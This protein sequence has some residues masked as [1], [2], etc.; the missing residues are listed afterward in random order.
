MLFHFSMTALHHTPFNP[1]REQ[2]DDKI[3]AYMSPYF[4]QDWHLF[5]PE[6]VTED[7]GF[8]IRAQRSLPD[9][10]VVTTKWVDVTTPH[11]DKLHRQRFWPSRVERLAPAVR[12]R[13]DGWRDPQLEELR[14]EDNPPGSKGPARA[15]ATAEPVPPLA[16]SELA[17]R[18]SALLYARALAS[19]EAA[20][21]W[22][23]SLRSVQVRIVINKYPRFSE[24]AIRAN[25]GKVSYYD[26]AWMKPL[27]VSR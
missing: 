20:K 24:R 22:G 7:S 2:H 9:G 19:A 1:I 26:L 13:L 23:G 17:G 4:Q 15:D 8:L 21:L 12:Q 11:I 14:R 25:R 16:P 18:D 10:A 5:A 27:K 6:P 3:Q